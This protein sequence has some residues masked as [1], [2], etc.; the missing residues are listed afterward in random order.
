MK[1]TITVCDV[2]QAVKGETNHWWKVWLETGVFHVTAADNDIFIV[3]DNSESFPVMDICGQQ[4]VSVVF[5]HF[6]EYGTFDRDDEQPAPEP[7]KPEE[8]PE[9]PF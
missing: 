1:K 9:M 6:L 4:H 2:C 7:I 3:A 5:S 8:F